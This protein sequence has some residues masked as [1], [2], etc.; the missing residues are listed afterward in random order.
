M[1][2]LRQTDVSVVVAPRES[3]RTWPSTFAR[4]LETIPP[5][6][7]VVVVPGGAPRR[8]VRRLES[9]ADERVRFVGPRRHLAPNAARAIGLS[10]CDTPLVAIIDNDVVTEPGWLAPL[11]LRA[12]ESA[13][14]AVTPLILGGATGRETI[15]CAGGD[16]HL[17]STGGAVRLVES[18]DRW[19]CDIGTID[20][21]EAGRTE[22]FEFHAVLLDRSRVEHVGG[23]DERMMSQYDH[24]DLVLRLRADG[25]EVWFEPQSHVTY[26]VPSWLSPS[27]LVFFLGRWSRSWNRRSDDAFR[28]VHGVTD[29]PY[30]SEAYR[31]SERH[32]R[33]AWSGVANLLKPA[34]GRRVSSGLSGALDWGL[35]RPLAS[36]ALRLAPKF[37][38]GGLT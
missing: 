4:L 6:C 18:H 27:D 31:Y 34:V 3:Y 9:L 20:D 29:A 32:R 11:V 23:I 37:R 30:S 19:G 24:I 14:V 33:F 21:L 8:I 7:P 22:L 35:G 15:H 1:H 5:E 13:A 25:G 12:K 17:E 26:A 36:L 16:C 38:G 2:D 10:D 28:S